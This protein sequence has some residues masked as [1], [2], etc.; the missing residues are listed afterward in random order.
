MYRKVDGDLFQYTYLEWDVQYT[1][2]SFTYLEPC[3]SESVPEPPCCCVSP[4][5]AA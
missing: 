2:I 4:R 1:Y 5:A 3:Y